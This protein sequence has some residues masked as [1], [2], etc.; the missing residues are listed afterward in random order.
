MFDVA[1]FDGILKKVREFNSSLLSDQ[2]VYL[3]FP[4]QL[5]GYIFVSLRCCSPFPVY[6]PSFDMWLLVMLD[7]N[8]IFL[9][10]F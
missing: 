4:L 2:V 1:Q 7:I 5:N 8:K 9:V 10:A 3:F 6:F